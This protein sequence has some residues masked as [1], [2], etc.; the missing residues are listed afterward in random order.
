MTPKL[1]I[2]S[3]RFAML[4]SFVLAG[5]LL[6]VAA[7]AER[8]PQ[9][10][11]NTSLWR[12]RGN[13]HPQARAEFDR[14]AVD[15]AMPME[16]MKLVFQLTP[17]QQSSLDILLRQQLDPSSPNYH[18]WLTPEQYADR[19][20]V[21][22]GDMARAANWLRQ[23]GFT[24]VIPAR[25]RTWISFNGSAAQ[26]EAAF[27]TPVHQ[28]LVNGKMHYANANEPSL[29]GA[30]RGLVVAIGP[31]N[32][33]RP[34]PHAVVKSVQPHFTSDVSGKH[35][36]APDDFA[37]IYDVR[38]LYNSGIDGSFE[39]IAV[40]GQTDL[41]TDSNHNNQ[42][43]V[44]TFRSAANLAAAN[45]QVIL[46]PGQSDPG[47]DAAD[48]D[49]ANLDLEWSS[50]VARNAMLI[51][52]NSKNVLFSSLPYAVDQNL[53]PVISV[54]YGLCEAQFSSSEIAT[55]TSA[56][57]QANAQGQTIVAS[58]GDSGP[59]DC[60]YSADPNN[61]VKS[62]THGYAVDVPAS[63]PYVTG[64][65]GA[66]FSEG[67][68][69]GATQYWSGTNNSNSGSAIS[70]IPEMTWND[71]ASDGSLAAGGGGVST[72]FTKPSWQSGAGVPAD[73]QR[74]VPDLAL[75]SSADHDGYLICSR[76]SCVSGFRRADQTLNVL[77]GTSAATPTFAGIVALI[78]QQTNQPQGNVNPILYGLA[79]SAPSAFHDITVGDNMVP[80]TQGTKDCPNG[81]S[82]GFSAGP[83][84]DL[85]T[86][87]GSVDVGALAAAWNG[88]TNPDFRLSAQSASLALTRGTPATD[89]LTVTGLAGYSTGVNLTCVVSS[90]LTNTSCSVSPGSVNPGGTAILTVTAS[91]L[92]ARLRPNPLLRAG[93]EMANGLVFAAGLLFTSTSRRRSRR[94]RL[95][96]Y[97]GLLG[98]LAVS[99]LLGTV[100]CGGGGSTSSPQQS[101]PQPQSGTVTVQASSGSLNHSVQIS[102]TVN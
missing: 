98:L 90:T 93:W 96:H 86:G 77:G 26:V 94:G 12:L 89:L 27:H 55:L 1:A 68:D 56:A 11:D 71:T 73:G 22:S 46:V 75:S 8:I 53:A 35:F 84:Y 18:K 97:R 36:L 85:A 5:V 38:G 20:G 42:Y 50:A 31:L 28:Y 61:P 40:L 69:T 51:Y 6:P 14:G 15:G 21:S 78:V 76:S 99:L 17:E 13:V 92:S 60:D 33:F 58:T 80:C 49:E 91:L 70:Y 100:S 52:V 101:V 9:T 23:Q 39:T 57:M 3:R 54:S 4:L 95:S 48:Q 87:L 24:A 19:F 10:I 43:D 47:S 7:R 81:G 45:L 34:R 32:S 79:A 82:I 2:T 88:P 63:L 37:T 83:G 65:G 25:S 66:E 29:P 41:S 30:F 62:A 72:L 44:Q 59:A 67:N 64:M 74:D 102:V 16:G